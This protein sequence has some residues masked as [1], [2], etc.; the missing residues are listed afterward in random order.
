MNVTGSWLNTYKTKQSPASYDPV[1]EWKGS[2]GP[3]LQSFNAGAYDYRLFTNLSY[4]LASF[5]VN[6][7]WRHLPEVKPA[8]KAT[9]AAIIANNA[10]VVA[11]GAG[12]RLSY[13][14]T[15]A[16]N[17]AQFDQFDL[18]AFWTINDTLSLRFG[19]DNVLDAQPPA[20]GR[21]AG[22][23]YN[24]ALT[25]AQNAANLAAVC[26]GAVGCQN[27]TAYSLPNSGLGTTNGGFYDVLGR[28]YFVAVKAKF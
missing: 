12:T 18:S 19:V 13:T 26:A 5:G 8:A 10:R 9:E 23:P 1:I 3:A 22:R 21:T 24:S 16:Y 28:R 25:P 20:T 6:L 7:R 15:T 2:L 27:P 11:G 17:I 4:N 14:P